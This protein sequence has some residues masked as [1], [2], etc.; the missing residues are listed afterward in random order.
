[1]IIAGLFVLVF[2]ALVMWLLSTRGVQ[3][4]T[5]Q[6]ANTLPPPTPVVVNTPV[7]PAISEPVAGE[8]TS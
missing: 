1:M 2:L 8:P 6:V 7:V 5:P 4:L 3:P